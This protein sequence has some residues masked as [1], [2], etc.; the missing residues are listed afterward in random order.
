MLLALLDV[1]C[2]F[3]ETGHIVYNLVGV[4]YPRNVSVFT[5]FQLG[6]VEEVLVFLNAFPLINW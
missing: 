6:R 5:P 1:S 2:Y 3:L 4:Y